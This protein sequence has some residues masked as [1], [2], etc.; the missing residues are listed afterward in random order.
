MTNCLIIENDKKEIEK[1]SALKNEFTDV[2]FTFIAKVVETVLNLILKSDFSL[3]FFNLDSHKINLPEILPLS[4]A[5][6]EKVKRNLKSIFNVSNLDDKDL[7]A[8]AREKGF[9]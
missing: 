9:I 5:R 8:I 3:I 6:V 4:I 7:I 1:I 2:N